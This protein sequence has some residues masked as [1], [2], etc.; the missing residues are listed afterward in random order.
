MNIK[1]DIRD[2]F[3][4]FIGN[5]EFLPKDFDQF[6]SIKR[7]R[8]L[9]LVL[10]NNIIKDACIFTKYEQ[11]KLSNYS[12]QKAFIYKINKMLPNSC[13]FIQKQNLKFNFCKNST[14]IINAF[15][16]KKNLIIS[17]ANKKLLNVA[18]L[19]SYCYTNKQ[20]QI[21]L[22]KDLLFHE[23][24]YQ[25]VKRLHKNKEVKDLGNAISIKGKDVDALKI[26]T[27][28][29]DIK[30]NQPNIKEEVEYA[31][32]SIKNENYAQVYLVY[33]KANDF[34]RHIPVYVD[35]L[36]DENYVIK[37]IPYS[38]RSTIR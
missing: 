2:N 24:V 14:L 3:L 30:T 16:N 6:T 8:Q 25:K 38:L 26:Y 28:W 19:I 4:G 9:F 37:A 11:K 20:M 10:S 23:F 17:T 32:K 22:D 12:L 35:E 34:K 27:S 18:R 36:K 21:L 29:K 15:K 13:I 5:T 31:I 7:L 33:P 1:F